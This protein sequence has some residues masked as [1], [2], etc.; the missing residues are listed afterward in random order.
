MQVVIGGNSRNQGNWEETP[1]DIKQI[2]TNRGQK[3]AVVINAGGADCSPHLGFAS[4]C[5]FHD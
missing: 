4:S 5:V 3:V 1:G 2:G